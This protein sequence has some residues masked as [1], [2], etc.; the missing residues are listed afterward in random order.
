MNPYVI[1]GLEEKRDYINNLEL[2]PELNKKLQREDL[3]AIYRNAC[4]YFDIPVDTPHN[5]RKQKSCMVRHWATFIA[6]CKGFTNSDVT[7]FFG[8]TPAMAQHAM[9]RVINEIE[10]YPNARIAFEHFI[11]IEA[12]MASYK[13]LPGNFLKPWLRSFYDQYQNEMHLVAASTSKKT[14]EETISEIKTMIKDLFAETDNIYQ[15]IISSR[16]KDMVDKLFDK[17]DQVANDDPQDSIPPNHLI[18]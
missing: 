1:P 9:K 10:V 12:L 14:K 5:C 13:K 7:D 11:N 15:H 2:E 4:I 18:I 6:K 16:D 3:I 17:L 8:K